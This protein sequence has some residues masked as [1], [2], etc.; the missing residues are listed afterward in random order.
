MT[1]KTFKCN[2]KAIFSYNLLPV[3]SVLVIQNRHL[4]QFNVND[5]QGY[6]NLNVIAI[7]KASKPTLYPILLHRKVNL[8]LNLSTFHLIQT[9]LVYCL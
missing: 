3:Y 7:E 9:G 5:R 1:F 6:E 8:K 2:F 4:F